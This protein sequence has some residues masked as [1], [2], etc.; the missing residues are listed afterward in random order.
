MGIRFWGIIFIGTFGVL[1]MIDHLAA[2]YLPVVN[3]VAGA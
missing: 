3:M 2:Q 1:E